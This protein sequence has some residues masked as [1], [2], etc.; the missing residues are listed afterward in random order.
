[1]RAIGTAVWKQEE[2]EQASYFLLGRRDQLERFNP[3]G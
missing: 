3:K 1:M 2:T